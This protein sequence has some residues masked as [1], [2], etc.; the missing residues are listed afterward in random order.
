[1]KD[2]RKSWLTLSLIPGLGVMTFWRLIAHFSSPQ[3]VLAATQKELYQVP[4]VN[5]RY[6]QG[7]AEFKNKGLAEVEL[8]RLVQIGGR[9]VVWGDSIYPEMLK[10]L[11]DPPPVFYVLGDLSLLKGSAVAVVGSRSASQYGIRVA[12]DL[13]RSLAQAG[14]VVVSGLA[15]GIDTAAHRGALVASGTTVAVLGCGL[16]W[17]YPKQNEA[18]YREIAAKGLLVSEYPLG[19]KPDRFRFPARNRIIASL[20]K[21]VLV[22]EATRK[23]G[24][25]IT[26]QIALDCGREV[27]AVPGQIDSFKSQGCHALIRSGAVLVSRVEDVLSEISLI[28]PKSNVRFENKADAVPKEYQ[29]LLSFVDVYPVA[30][31]VLVEKTG[32]PIDRVNELCLLLELEGVIESVPGDQIRRTKE[33]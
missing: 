25:L 33:R 32:L 16:D 20:V 10:Q 30:K 28:R 24:S 2:H 21:G 17:I 15:A 4:G 1:M 22:V 18:L 31:D 11:P 27:F 14:V 29:S 3:A 6:L 26:A 7:L 13:S 23:S 9:A 5:Q 19:T 8:A 12:T